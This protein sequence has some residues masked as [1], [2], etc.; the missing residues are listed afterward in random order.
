MN[1]NVNNHHDRTYKYY[2]N[3]LNSNDH[4]LAVGE[5][6]VQISRQVSVG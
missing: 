3:F 6:I 1:F 4:S 5:Y 2:N